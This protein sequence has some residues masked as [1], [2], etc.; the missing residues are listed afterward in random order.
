MIAY[1]QI[2][3]CVAVAT[4]KTPYGRRK[5][6][7]CSGFLSRLTMEETVLVWVRKGAFSLDKYLSPTSIAANS[8]STLLK[9]KITLPLPPPSLSTSILPSPSTSSSLSGPST[10]PH[11]ITTLILVGPGT[12][13]APMRSILH[14]RLTIQEP[15]KPPRSVLFFG[16]RKQQNDFLYE[17]EWSS[18]ARCN[19]GNNGDATD[20][21]GDAKDNEDAVVIT[22]FSRDQP[23]KIYVT[24][25]IRQHGSLVWSLLNPNTIPSTRSIVFVSGAAKRMPADVRQAFCDVICTYGENYN[26]ESAGTLLQQMEKEGRYIVEAWS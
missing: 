10:T 5:T 26:Q 16:C 12:G 21:M 19:N 9:E 6:G 11:L 23:Q 24:D 1:G 4:T 8:A 13:V 17:K 3:L 20:D 15:V 25:K 7:L 2:H 14:E 18:L 22:A